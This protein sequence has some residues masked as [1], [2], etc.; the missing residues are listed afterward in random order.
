[1]VIF[2]SL[3]FLSFSADILEKLVI[4]NY[5]ELKRKFFFSQWLIIFCEIY[6]FVIVDFKLYNNRIITF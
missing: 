2:P 6:S 4:T 5:N 1:M 3:T